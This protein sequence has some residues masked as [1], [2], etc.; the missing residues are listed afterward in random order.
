MGVRCVV[1][2][3]GRGSRLGRSRPKPLAPVLG[4]TLVERVV[5][6]AAQVGVDDFFVVTGYE[7]E[8]VEAFLAGLTLRRG[9]RIVPVRND[10]W[11]QG[12][13]TSALAAR[14]V[15]DDEFMLIMGD[16]VFDEQLL[17]RL[18]EQPIE[19]GGVVVGADFRVGDDAIANDAD[20]TKLLV[21]SEHVLEIGKSLTQ[22]NAYDTG[23]FLC[24]PALFDALEASSADHDGSLSAGVQLLAREG[25]VRAFDIGTNDWVDVDT[26]ADARRVQARLRATMTKPEDG[27]VARVVNR[28][29][30]GRVLTPMLLR[31]WPRV[32]ANE[33]SVL[34]FTVA[35]LA[36]GF[37]LADWPVAAGA[38]VALASILDGSDGEIARLKQQRSP[39]G[40]YFDAVLDRYADTA[41]LAA[42][43]I[44]ARRH[45]GDWTVVAV[46]VAAVVGNLMVSYTS[47]R[48]VV[49]LGYRYRGRWTAAGRGRDLRLFLLSVAAVLA[50]FAPV[51]VMGALSLIA[52][53]TNGIVAGRLMLSWRLSR[54]SPATDVE[55]VVF[56]LDG[57][58]ADTMPF[59]TDLAVDV[60]GRYGL[61][62]NETRRRYLETVGLDFAGQLE[63]LFPGDQA[64][65]VVAAE[66]ETRKQQGFALCQV[67]P[68]LSPTLTFLQQAGVRRF[69]SSSTTRE[70][71]ASYLIAHGIDNAFD[72]FTGFE[73]GYPKNRQVE[74]LIRRHGLAPDRV[75]FVGDSPRDADLLRCVGVRFVGIE[76]LFARDDFRWRGL[77]SVR[78]LAALTR[79]WRGDTRRRLAVVTTGSSPRSLVRPS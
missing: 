21:E 55:A 49:D 38:M 16:H 51:A 68:D 69:L 41:M 59:L 65:P 18:L 72:D 54:S 79:R 50:P 61:T 27:F 5:V 23:A 1:L 26:A 62:A 32:T 45:A 4:L 3:A 9:I 19:P 15:V 70:L 28:R 2:A 44:F 46:G 33:V 37:F 40:G 76:R 11:P 36:T 12:N 64:N 42:A 25:R 52:V 35:L 71:V 58:V 57:T 63:E 75:L 73:P 20:A 34:A 43:A 29:L 47:A 22:Y 78:D 30:S 53:M 60:I 67:F 8:R 14:A 6:T 39:F 56:D 24:H 77:H 7:A 10:A 66:F 17:R 31:L 48:S 74:L 13:G